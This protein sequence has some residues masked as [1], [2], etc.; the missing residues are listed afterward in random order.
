MK[1]IHTKTFGFRIVQER[2]QTILF[3][4]VTSKVDSAITRAQFLIRSIFTFLPEVLN[5]RQG[6]LESLASALDNENEIVSNSSI[7][8]HQH[9]QPGSCIVTF[10]REHW[11]SML[12]FNLLNN[13]YRVENNPKAA[14]IVA[15][16]MA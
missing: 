1:M 6:S 4:R 10:D 7:A 9:H 11:T 14:Q 15:K 8:F 12:H 3:T 5:M 16:P 2:Y 13:R